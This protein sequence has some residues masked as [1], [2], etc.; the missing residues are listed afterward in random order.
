MKRVLLLILAT[1]LGVA[2]LTG[3]ANAAT[4]TTVTVVAAGDIAC[5]VDFNVVTPDQC[6]QAATARRAA[7]VNAKYALLLGDLAFPRDSLRDLRATFAPTWGKLTAA[8]RPTPGNHGDTKVSFSDYDRFFGA[9]ADPLEPGCVRNCLNYYSFGTGSW[10]IVSLNTSSCDRFGCGD[11]RAELKWLKADLAEHP[12]KCNLA[13]M[14][15]PLFSLGVAGNPGVK[16]LWDVLQGYGVDVVLA[17]HA[18]NYQR[19]AP[20]LPSGKAAG[21]GIT[22]I[23]AGTGG[24]RQQPVAVPPLPPVPNLRAAFKDFGVVQLTLGPGG[25]HSQFDSITGTVRDRASGTCHYGPLSPV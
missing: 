4:G 25:W 19:F 9:R 3:T 22:E 7:Q 1:L 11:L 20:Q 21:N 15:T 24:D 2:M 6:Q 17:A 13:F 23:I 12:N 18:R 10:H 5:G 14:H 16:P 8:L